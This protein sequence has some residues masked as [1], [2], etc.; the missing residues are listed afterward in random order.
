MLQ[1]LQSEKREPYGREKF[2]ADLKAGTIGFASAMP[3]VMALGILSGI[4][5]VAGLHCFIVVGLVAALLGGARMLVS[6]PS[7]AMAVIVSTILADNGGDLAELALIAVMAGGM[8]VILGLF[9][10]GRFVSYLPHIVMAGFLSGIGAR[11]L[12]AQA[13]RI[14]PAGMDDVA[15]VSLSLAV[16]LLW[17]RKIERYVPGPLAGVGS[18]IVLSLF[19]PGAILLG[20]VP[21]GL[22]VPVISIPSI[23]VLAGAVGPASLLALISTGYTL[24]LA[25]T[26]DT[27]T[28][29]Q[30]NSNRQLVSLGI[31]NITAGLVGTMPG[32]GNLATLTIIRFGGR[33]VVAGVVTALLL[34]ALLAFFGPYVAWI[35]VSALSAVILRVGLAIIEWGFLRRVF[36][37]RTDFVAVM[38]TTMGLAFFLDPLMAVIF[39]V[40]AANA[41][42]ADRLEQLELDSVISVP[43]LDSVFLKTEDEGDPFRARAGLLEFRGAFT[44]ASSRKLVRMIGDD[45]REHD[46]VIFDLSDLTHIDDS[47]AHLIS[48]LI[49]RA[50]QSGT[51]IIFVGIPEKV[52]EVFYAFNV[53]RN[54]PAERIVDTRDEARELAIGILN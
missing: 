42:N 45:I 51:E 16:M 8:Q 17:P 52:H 2:W 26:A 1:V 15:I 40:I 30:H 31:A 49:D 46:L 20:E 3:I 23:G 13:V 12:W 25:V 10:I 19:L 6:G 32:S 41:I 38:L 28:G 4:G 7:V 48:L 24:M 50:R 43:L 27:F 36:N 44:V 22:P 5:P 37:I 9:G 33:T 29:G 11:I 53:L 39:G 47:S 34:A 14:F 21:T 35:P 54:V 18:G